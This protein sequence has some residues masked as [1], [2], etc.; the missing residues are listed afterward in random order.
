MTRLGRFLDWSRN[1]ARLF[2]HFRQDAHS[3]TLLGQTTSRATFTCSSIHR[4]VRAIP[5]LRLIFAYHPF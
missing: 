2:Q 3:F 5:S 1:E 4:Y